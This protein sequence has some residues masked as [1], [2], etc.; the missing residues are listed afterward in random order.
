MRQRLRSRIQSL[1]DSP[2]YTVNFRLRPEHRRYDWP[3]PSPPSSTFNS[4]HLWY[5]R[6]YYWRLNMWGLVVLSRLLFPVVALSPAEVSRCCF[7]FFLFP[8]YNFIFLLP[9]FVCLSKTGTKPELINDR[10]LEPPRYAFYISP[11]RLSISCSL[12]RPPLSLRLSVFAPIF[13]FPH[14][15]AAFPEQKSLLSAAFLL[16]I[17][18]P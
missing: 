2:I 5:F 9:L 6:G 17:S 3:A 11:L 7:F 13:L 10:G 1:T 12:N 4:K 14:L 15:S 8:Y 16:N 18:R